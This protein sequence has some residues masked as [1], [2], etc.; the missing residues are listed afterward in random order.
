MTLALA[1]G[2]N[3]GTEDVIGVAFD[4]QD[5]AVA[6]LEITDIQIAT[7]NGTLSSFS[8]SYVIGADLVA[9]N[10][11]LDPGFNTS[12][13]GSDEPYDVGVILDTRHF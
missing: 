6:G 9:D 2:S 10:G 3:S 12:G 13:G 5:D 11:A 1:P 8:A 7:D 4:I